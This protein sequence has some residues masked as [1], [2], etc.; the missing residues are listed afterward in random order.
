[1][2]RGRH[3]TSHVGQQTLVPRQRGQPLG[4]HAATP[5]QQVCQEPSHRSRLPNQQQFPMANGVQHLRGEPFLLTYLS[6]LPQFVAHFVQRTLVGDERIRF[7][8]QVG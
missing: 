6:G 4:L 7:E 8:T 5:S 1:L 2:A 3:P